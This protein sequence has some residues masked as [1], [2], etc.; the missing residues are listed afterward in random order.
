[1]E[2]FYNFVEIVR[3]LRR[4]C[5]WDRE[6]THQSLRRCLLEETYEVLEAID[7]ND[8]DEL[9]KELGDLILQV[10]FHSIIAEENNIFNI[11]EVL[12]IEIKKLISRHPHIF[13]DVKVSGSEEVKKNWESIKKKEGRKSV[14]DGVPKELPALFRAYRIQEKAS[15]VGFDW[16]DIE[17]V[18]EKILEE[19]YELKNVITQKKHNSGE[20]AQYVNELENEFGDVLFALVNYARFLKIN[21]ED[22]LRKTIE[23]F[24]F[25]FNI[26]EKYAEENNLDLK[27]ISLEQMDKIWNESK[28][29]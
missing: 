23:K 16:T 4:E 20:N 28:L 25:R 18:F 22:A 26:I 21:P 3:K 9:K 14:L 8:I 11:E 19:I 7:T 29:L 27:D 10:V 15:K 13:A 17:P 1:M 12:D 24:I 2:K 5:P 6:Q